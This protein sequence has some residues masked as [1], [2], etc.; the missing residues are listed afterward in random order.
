MHVLYAHVKKT[1]TIKSFIYIVK[2]INQRL[3]HK[4]TVV[5]VCKTIQLLSRSKYQRKKLKSKL[6]LNFKD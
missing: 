3:L 2:S 4:K 6:R 1:T 5:A